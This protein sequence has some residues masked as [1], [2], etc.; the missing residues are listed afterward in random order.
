MATRPN[1]E[2]LFLRRYGLLYNNRLYQ[3]QTMEQRPGLGTALYAALD[4]TLVHSLKRL[5]DPSPGAANAFLRLIGAGTKLYANGGA[6]IDT[7]YSG[8]PLSFVPY[9]PDQS[10]QPWMYVADGNKLVK[11]RSDKT[12]Y[13]VGVAPPNVAPSAALAAPSYATIDN[14]TAV[15]AWVNAGTAGALAAGA[16][17]N[18]TI[19][20]ILYDSGNTGWAS[21]RP[22]LLDDNIQ[23]GA[24]ITINSGGGTAETVYIQEVS[25]AAVSTTIAAIV[26]DSGATGMC[27]ITP[28]IGVADPGVPDYDYIP[29]GDTTLPYIYDVTSGQMVVN[30]EYRGLRRPVR[31]VHIAALQ[32]NS[33]V[34]LNSGGANQEYVRILSVTPGPDGTASFRCSCV[35]THV[36][37]ETVTSVPSFRVYCANTHAAAET[38]TL[39]AVS[40]TVTAGAGYISVTAGYNLGY[41]GSRPIQPD[42]LIHVSIKIDNLENLIEG[43]LILDVD[44]STNDFAHNALYVV[45]RPNDFAR[46]VAG[47]V[48]QIAG[49]QQ[50]IQAAFVT[51]ID[52]TDPNNTRRLA[53]ARSNVIYTDPDADMTGGPGG[54]GGRVDSPGGEGLGQTGTGSNQWH[55][56]FFRAGDFLRLG[57]DKSRTLANV[58]AVRFQFQ[59]SAS[60]VVS[61]S[62]LWEGGTYGPD[63]GLVGFPYLYRY[64][65]RSSASGARSNLSPAMRSGVTPRRQ[66]VNLTGTQSADAQVDKVD[67]YRWGGGLS[68][69]T[70]IGTGTNVNPPVFSDVYPDSTIAGNDQAE[71]NNFRPFPDLDL[72]RSGT[73]NVSG[74]SVA[75]AGG[76]NFNTAWA[77]GSEIRI[78]GFV[79]HLYASPTSTSKLE[80]VENAGN[81]T[82][83]TFE[84][85]QAT[86]L[87]QPL[88]VIWGPTEDT[89]TFFACGSSYQPGVLFWTNGNN[90]DSASDVN[91][92]EISSGSEPLMNGCMVSS[93]RPTVASTE[94]WWGLYPQLQGAGWNPVQL[95]ITRG[96]FARWFM[97]SDGE[98]IWFGA[99][100]GIY[101]SVGGNREYSITDDEL[102]PLFPHDGQ[103]G[104]AVTVGPYTITPP[105]LTAT[106]Y[107][108]LSTA[109][110]YLYFDFKDTLG[111]YATLVYDTK[112]K[113][114]V[115]YDVYGTPVLCHYGEEGSGVHSVLCG[116]NDGKV[117]QMAG[118]SDAGS[119][120]TQA[121]WSPLRGMPSAGGLYPFFCPREAYLG[122]RST[123]ASAVTLKLLVDGVTY[124]YSVT[125]TAGR[126][127][128]PYIPLGPLKGKMWQYG[129]SSTQSV[130]LY[131]PDLEIHGKFWGESGPYQPLRPFAE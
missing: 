77:P 17:T 67:W 44:P 123:A 109:D 34:L 93:N 71:T 82:G 53:P 2:L 84:L 104:T 75:R 107:L 33:L 99:K 40:S 96:L 37:A 126:Q 98:N 4:Q 116:G 12:V 18:T 113:G 76:D 101:Q 117:Y 106:A 43:R 118:S 10:V 35:N 66:Q 20:A 81:L 47:S 1:P 100:D 112:V 14:L 90:P 46:V 32:V 94:H 29:S 127:D 88:P 97:C 7:G 72:P 36:A 6:A 52:Y 114:W 120:V 21:I 56:F 22:V 86:L 48:T 128:K 65:Y 85:P 129:V 16:R 28:T 61:V 23:P 60:T 62:S 80:L 68:Q 9:R 24:A 50:A 3:P 119:D 11:V 87:G 54:G 115:S 125:A 124:T 42:D 27:T 13:S 79:F 69:W 83:V 74:T 70:Y 105:D 38:L 57:T 102:K 19:T 41:I 5:N 64:R 45:F 108:R 92:L 130:R 122:V 131:L 121:V 59:V 25:N 63:V 15:G 111:N 110:G 39:N 30:P 78:N 8:N 95:P 26:Y 49:Q 55:E 51:G 91:Q 58:A 73:C 103:A 89:G 31:Q